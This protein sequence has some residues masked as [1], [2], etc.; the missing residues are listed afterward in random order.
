M[1]WKQRKLN[2]KRWQRWS[3]LTRIFFGIFSSS[4]E[5]VWGLSNHDIGSHHRVELL[6][7]NY[8]KYGSWVFSCWLFEVTFMSGTEHPFVSLRICTNMNQLKTM[9]EY[10]NDNSKRRCN[11]S[12]STFI[13]MR[14]SNCNHWHFKF[15]IPQR[16]YFQNHFPSFSDWICRITHVDWSLLMA[17]SPL[18][19]PQRREPD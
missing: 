2:Y 11:Q 10:D 1:G 6:L 14:L 5:E 8:V 13:G 4:F 7:G 3:F 17:V 12:P 15:I 16:N 18:P 19:N 9:R